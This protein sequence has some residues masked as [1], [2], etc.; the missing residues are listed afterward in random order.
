MHLSPVNLFTVNSRDP[1]CLYGTLS[2]Q[3]LSGRQRLVSRR[4][5]SRHAM[6][7]V[8]TGFNI[9]TAWCNDWKVVSCPP[10]QCGAL[11]HLPCWRRP[12]SESLDNPEPAQNWSR[13]FWRVHAPLGLQSITVMHLRCGVADSRT[14]P[15]QLMCPAPTHRPGGPEHP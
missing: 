5:F 3:P 7:L 2:S 12:S 11:H 9:N 14:H 13:P 6:E 8:N 4:P 10:V 1:H 15:L